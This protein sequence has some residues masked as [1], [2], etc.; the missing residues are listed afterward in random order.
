MRT[1]VRVERRSTILHADLDSFYAS[2]EQRDDPRLRGRP[3]I[4][5]GGRRARGQLRGQAPR[6]AHGDGRRG[7]APA[8]P[9]RGRR[10][11]ADVRLLGGEQGGLRGLRP[12]RRRWS[13]RSRSTRPSSTSAGCA[14]SR[15]RRW[16]SPCA[17]GSE[18][19]ERVGLPITVGVARTKFLAKVASALAKPDGLLVVP[20]G[21]ELALLHLL[22]VERLWGVGPGHRRRSSTTAGSPPSARSPGSPS[23]RSS[24][25]SAARRDASSTRWPTT[26]TRGRCGSASGGARWA[27]STRSGRR[28]R[29]PEELDAVLVG[30]VDRIARRLRAA[31]RV[32]RTV[33]LRLRFEDFSRATRSHTLPHATQQTEP[34]LAT[35]RAL[36][37]ARPA[38][39]RVPGPDPPRDRPH[40]PRGR[41]PTSS[42]CSP[43][44]AAARSTRRSTACAT[45]SARRPSPARCCSAATRGWPSR[46]CRTEARVPPDRVRHGHGR[47]ARR[48]RP[49]P[50]T[51][52]TTE[53]SDQNAE[54]SHP[55]AGPGSGEPRDSGPSP[56]APDTS[57]EQEGDAG[58]ATGNPDA[59]G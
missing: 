12:T 26:A 16:T 42:S 36:L 24:R 20:P 46:C 14:A 25:W 13:R 39:D 37:A 29:S 49:R 6:R 50:T 33:V 47:R 19:L 41:R 22:P 52:A 35:A 5:G 1:S 30:I 59:A 48:P 34:I 58:Q 38:D 44:S 28:R 55:G 8:V 27:R 57:H 15:G 4:V 21:G 2:V 43:S 53:T 45:A 23:R 54:E 56:D 11:A 3:V 7:G 31:R 9:A 18:V 40:Q 51:P 10:L 17:C 32:C